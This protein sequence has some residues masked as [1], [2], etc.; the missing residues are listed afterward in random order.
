MSEMRKKRYE[1][2]TMM[3]RVLG[4]EADLLTVLLWMD[5]SKFLYRE[6]LQLL[7]YGEMLRRLCLRNPRMRQKLNQR[8]RKSGREDRD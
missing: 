4:Q 1:E 8:G 7:R 6:C 2:Q 5:R 3:E